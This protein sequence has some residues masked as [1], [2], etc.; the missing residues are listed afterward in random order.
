MARITEKVLLYLTYIA[1]AIL[2]F[3]TLSVTFDV[4][5]RYIFNRPSQWIVDVCEYSLVFI[6]FLTVGWTLARG[7]HVEISLVV[8]ILPGKVQ[9]IFSITTSS[10]GT[11]ICGFLFYKSIELIWELYQAKDLFFKALVIP[12]WTVFTVVPLGFLTLTV[13]FI[14]AILKEIKMF[15]NGD[16]NR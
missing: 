15:S 3:V 5:M 10:I 8:N 2:I 9:K 16:T 6:L 12:K 1:G 4:I 13:Q 11:L 14:I 7:G